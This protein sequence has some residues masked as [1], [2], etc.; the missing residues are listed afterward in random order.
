MSNISLY[1]N[2]KLEEKSSHDEHFPR[3]IS[4]TDVRVLSQPNTR[5]NYLVYN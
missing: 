2:F 1:Q 4:N 5:N 3:H